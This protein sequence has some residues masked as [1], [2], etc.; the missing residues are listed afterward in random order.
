MLL[1][2]CTE[3]FTRLT[4]EFVRGAS[5]F[6]SSNRAGRAERVAQEARTLGVRHQRIDLRPCV[7]PDRVENF[8]PAQ[9][10]GDDGPGHLVL[11]CAPGPCR[12]RSCASVDGSLA[13]VRSTWAA[14]NCSRVRDASSTISTLPPHGRDRVGLLEETFPPASLLQPRE[15]PGFRRPMVDLPC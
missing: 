12:T 10:A 2:C 13:S 8:Q 6:L 9:C 7:E 11:H 5:W 1:T 4:L 3:S 15:P 14:R